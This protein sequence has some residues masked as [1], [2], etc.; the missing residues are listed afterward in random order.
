MSHVKKS[1]KRVCETRWSSKHDAVDAVA[2][3]T[4]GFIE[5]LE[6]LRDGDSETADTKGM[7]EM[8]L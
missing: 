2:S 3:C 1:V 4:E 5:S 7:L 8:S 6:E